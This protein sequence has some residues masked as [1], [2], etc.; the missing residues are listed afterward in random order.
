MLDDILI[1]LIYAHSYKK[2]LI[3]KINAYKIVK[4]SNFYNIQNSKNAWYYD[5]KKLIFA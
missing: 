4:D 5:I 1:T 2:A 3:K